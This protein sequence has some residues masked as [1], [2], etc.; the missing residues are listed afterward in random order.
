MAFKTVFQRSELKYLIT[1][2]QKNIILNEIDAFITPDI[3]G[4][5]IIRNVYFDT[6]NYRLIR[7]SIEHPIYKEKLRIRSYSRVDEDRDVFVEIK[8]KFA[9]TV[10]KRRIVIPERYAIDWICN[11]YPPPDTS[12]IASEIDYFISYY[13]SLTPKMFI[14]YNREAFYSIND[15][16]FRITF[17]TDI[18]ARTNDLTLCS[19]PYGTPICPSN[20]VLMEIKCNGGIPLWMTYI[21]SR[22]QIYKTSF[23]KYGTAYQKLVFNQNK[24]IFQYA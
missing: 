7:H 3:Y 1:N 23:S 5:S 9:K 10:N 19:N 14:C 13:G 6:D 8:K 22:E 24:E 11:R 2:E 4:K 15:V 17:D 12:Q 18:M 21:L 20:L 16:D